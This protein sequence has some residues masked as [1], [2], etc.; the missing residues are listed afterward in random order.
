M[1]FLK[2][3]TIGN[4]VITQNIMRNSSRFPSTT[5][6]NYYESDTILRR[7]ISCKTFDN[8]FSEKQGRYIHNTPIHVKLRGFAKI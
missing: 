1:Q 3:R 6:E 2:F 7:G 8:N 4:E 5:T